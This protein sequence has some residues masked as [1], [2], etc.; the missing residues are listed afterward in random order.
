MRSIVGLLMALALSL[1]SGCQESVETESGAGAEGG[2]IQ[3]RSLP[4]IWLD[5]L[6]QR[7]RIHEAVSKGTDMWHEEC[8]QISSAA[9]SIDG[10]ALEIRQRIA[11]NPSTEP[12]FRALADLLGY[13]QVS[14]AAFRE[15]AVEEVIGAFPSLMIGLDALLQ[16]IENHFT[17]DEIGSESVVTRPGFNTVHP[18]PPPS[19]V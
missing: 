19:P 1:G 3:A 15:N 2:Q 7:D 11:E 5:V 9:V 8:A 4:V 12:R 18:P 17:R 16:G 13:L 6:A 14:A 10:L